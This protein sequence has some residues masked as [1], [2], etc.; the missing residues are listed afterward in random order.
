MDCKD[1]RLN[2]GHSRNSGRGGIGNTE[3]MRPFKKFSY[4]EEGRNVI[5]EGGS[6]VRR[7]FF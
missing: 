3:Y 2:G 1:D 6:A 5:A 4:K 7:D